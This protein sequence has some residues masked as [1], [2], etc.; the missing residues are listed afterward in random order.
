MKK[1]IFILV[2]CFLLPAF[3]MAKAS[4]AGYYTNL[5]RNGKYHIV[6]SIST[7]YS[8][9]GGEDSESNQDIVL[10][11][12]KERGI[13]YYSKY[14]HAG[15][16]YI[17]TEL[18]EYNNQLYSRYNYS[19]KELD[20]DAEKQKPLHKLN[21]SHHTYWPYYATPRAWV[22]S[23]VFSCL[24]EISEKNGILKNY[25]TEFRKSG[26]FEQDGIL[27]N[28]DEYLITAP[29]KG[30]LQIQYQDGILISGIKLLNDKEVNHPLLFSN[31]MKEDRM[32]AVLFEKFDDDV[33]ALVRNLIARS[34]K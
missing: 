20:V 30:N 6:C 27:F 1:F 33:D 32:E 26:S 25:K 23:T 10:L 14:V 18:F 28:Y 22:I 11:E 13:S 3:N 19:K 8:R 24:G 31:R 12:D 4:Q 15:K 34:S 7:N 17:L 21:K 5:I 29:E 9:N 16:Y 2:L